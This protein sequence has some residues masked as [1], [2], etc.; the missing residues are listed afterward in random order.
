MCSWLTPSYEGSHE[1]GASNVVY[2]DSDDH[3]DCYTDDDDD[4]DDSDNVYTISTA[5]TQAI[6]NV[7]MVDSLIRR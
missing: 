4:D 3:G 2:D 7:L 5:I 6:Q 1:S